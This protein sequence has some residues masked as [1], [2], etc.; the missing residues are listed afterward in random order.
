MRQSA[1]LLAD[2]SVRLADL[3]FP[4]FRE[5][6][7]RT[8]LAYIHVENLL[9]F[10][11]IDRDGRID[12]YIAAWLPDELALLFLRG[13]ELISAAAFTEAGREVIPIAV[14]LDRMRKELERGELCYCEA[15]M[16]QLA[17]MYASCA[18]ALR[19]Y[20]V[21]SDDPGSLFNA[22]QQERFS[23]VL[24]LIS[25]GRV[26]YFRFDD[27]QYRTGYFTGR[28][29]DAPVPAFVEAQFRA[30]TDGT[31]P[32]LSARTFAHREGVPEQAS[33][34]LI[35]TYRDLFWRI[36]E[37][38]ERHAPDEALRRAYKVRDTL[39]GTHAPLDAIGI[40]RDR[41]A[42]PLVASPEQL[43]S[44]LSA[45]ALQLL[46]QLEVIVPGIAPEVLRDATREHR[47]VLQKAGFYARLPWTVSW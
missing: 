20:P 19:G 26:S 46:E 31:T 44:A 47:F 22:L 10:A 36:A 3:Q 38:S 39:Q 18:G 13:G 17:W 28:T 41:Q 34:A 27:G 25:D 32:L 5:H 40:P 21:R 43:T 30:H 1:A 4:W 35:E 8:R 42:V 2:S 29:E 16:E 45:W 11:K 12:G 7:R 6:I 37:A 23:G 33:P 9:H 15:P 24:E 14:A